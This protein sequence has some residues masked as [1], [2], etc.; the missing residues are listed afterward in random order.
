MHPILNFVRS[1]NLNNLLTGDWLTVKETAK[2]LHYS[3]QKVYKM[4]RDKQLDCVC[5]PAI[6]LLIN[7]ASVDE[8]I[9]RGT[10]NEQ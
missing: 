6:A 3:H 5:I 1:E 9:K 7:S 4:T 2:K 10:T 8:Y